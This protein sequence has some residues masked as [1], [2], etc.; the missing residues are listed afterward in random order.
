MIRTAFAVLA[1]LLVSQPASAFDTRFSVDPRVD[2]TEM[3]RT[4]RM[5][6][7]AAHDGPVISA[8]ASAI[9]RADSDLILEVAADFNAYVRM[10]MPFVEESHIVQGEGQ[11]NLFT[12]TQMSTLGQTSQHYLE[13]RIVKNLNRHSGAG[14]MWQLA[15]RRNSWPYPSDP[16]FTAL[17]GSFYVQPLAP[18]GDGTPRTY[19]RYYMA[20]DPD[21]SIPDSIVR[22]IAKRQFKRGVAQVIGAVA[23][24]AAKREAA[25]AFEGVD[26]SH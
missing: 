5:K 11:S 15:T 24:E 23:R 2:L 22:G 10:G 7:W 6:I 12:W 18:A 14:N 17:D 13:V 26:W 8:D 3:R 1:V 20:A 21:T 19:V 9:L 25:R 16:S 4:G